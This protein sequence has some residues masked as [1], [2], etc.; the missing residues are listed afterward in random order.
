MSQAARKQVGLRHAVTRAKTADE[1]VESDGELLLHLLARLGR[2]ILQDHDR[3]ERAERACEYGHH[4][5]APGTDCDA[6]RRHSQHQQE[7]D[8][9]RR[10]EQD[11]HQPPG[12]NGN[13]RHDEQALKTLAEALQTFRQV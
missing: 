2:L 3:Q 13:L 1:H 10:K 12:R 6:E 7:K 11:Q 4:E 8:C 9:D 5:Q